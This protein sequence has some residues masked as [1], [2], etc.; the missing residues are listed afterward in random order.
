MID[1]KLRTKSE[2]IF[3]K[4]HINNLLSE[5]ANYKLRLEILKMNLNQYINSEETDDSLKDFLALF[6]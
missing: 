6:E 2:F 4:C 3:D 1:E 5:E